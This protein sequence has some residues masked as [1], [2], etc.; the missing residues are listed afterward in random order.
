MRRLTGRRAARQDEGCFVIEGASLLAE[1]LNAGVAIET[2]VFARGAPM[3]LVKQAADGGARIVEAE[4]GVIER[5]ADVVTAQPLLAIA[6]QSSCD[7]DDLAGATFLVV[8]VQITDPGNLGT[9]VR[10]ARAAGA[11]GVVCLANCVDLYSPK[12]VRSTAGSMFH[13]P[14][15][16]LGGNPVDTMVRLG[17]Q[18][19]RLVGAVASGGDD[20][21]YVD[22]RQPV[23]VFIGNEAHGLPAEVEDRLDQRITIPMEADTESLNAAMAATVISFETARQRRSNP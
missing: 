3:D 10:G 12:V 22:L 20:L 8:A 16:V 1:A 19:M 23:A 17:Q 9:I 21:Y 18:G 4:V 13:I 2:V 11:G 15:A 6:K 7:L 5:V 14:V